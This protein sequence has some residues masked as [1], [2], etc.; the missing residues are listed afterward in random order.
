MAGSTVGSLLRTEQAFCS[1]LCDKQVLQF[2]IAY[3]SD[4]FVDLPET[5]Q[6]REVTLDSPSQVERAFSE[7][8][9]WFSQRNL[10]FHRWASADGAADDSVAEFLAEKGFQKR[11]YHA[12]ALAERVSFEPFDNV[13]VLHARAVRDALRQTFFQPSDA[14]SSPQSLHADACMERL[15]D[16]Q[17]DMYVA[18]VDKVP[19]GRCALYQVG[20]IARVMDLTV[21]P[22][23][24]GQG[25]DRALT[26]HVLTQ[27]HRL[28]IRNVCVQVDCTQADRAD[29]F[30]RAGF[31]VDSVIEVFDRTPT[32]LGEP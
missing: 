27:A 13:R 12:M 24:T 6:Y 32:S 1:Q 31:V 4:R 3:Y 7:A 28:A 9:A 14:P 15:D 23:F 30:R 29:W 16:P 25:V 10:C 22:A 19:A 17:F 26:K 2:G 20:D 18:L 11:T 5:N 8:E 21:L